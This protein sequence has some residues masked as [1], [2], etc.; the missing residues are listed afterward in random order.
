MSKITGKL[1]K[2]GDFPQNNT[3][4]PHCKS[5]KMVSKWQS[6]DS[7]NRGTFRSFSQLD[8]P[9]FDGGRKKKSESAIIGRRQ[10]DSRTGYL[11]L[12]CRGD[13]TGGFNQSPS[14]Q[15]PSQRI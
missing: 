9:T 8:L 13:S 2:F 1:L 7:G 15:Y 11:C 10:N 12:S 3:S 4:M 14:L 5:Q 6:M